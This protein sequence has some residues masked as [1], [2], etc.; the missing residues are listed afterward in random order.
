[1]AYLRIANLKKS[2]RVSRT[3]TQQVLRGINVEFKRG[4]FVAVLGESGCG[5][6]TFMNIL[7][8]LDQDYTGS[9]VLDG[10]F[11]KDYSEKKLDDYRK[12]RVGLIFQNYNLI[13]HMSVHENIEVAMTMSNIDRAERKARTQEILAQVGLSEYADKLPNQLSGGQRQR[14]AIAR[15]LANTP[16]ILLADEPPGALDKDSA[17][18]VIQILKKI[19]ESGKLVIV[20]THSQKVASAC[21]RILTIDDGVIKSDDKQYA[22]TTKTTKAQ[23]AKIQNIGLKELFKLAYSNILQTKKRSLLVSVGMSIGIAAVI[24][25]F[26]LSN[27]ITGYVDKQLAS[28]MNAL[29]MQV[30]SEASISSS[31]IE[32]IEELEGVDYVAE[33]TYVR[34][35]SFYDYG[36]DEGTI[37]LLSSAYDALDRDLTAGEI[38]EDGEILISEAFAKNLYNNSTDEAQ[39]LVGTQ[40]DITFGGHTTAFI[41]SG[42]YEDNSDYA[43]YA[44]AYVTKNNLSSMYEKADKTLRTNILYVYV[45]D[46]SYIT[47]VKESIEAMSYTVSRDDSTV[48]TLLGYVDLGTKVLTGFALISIAVSAIMIFIVT[49]TSVVE[50]TKEIG[51]LRAVGG[52]KKDVTL[53][54]ILESAM[55]GA[56]AGLIAVVFSLFISIVANLIMNQYVGSWLVSLNAVTYL[57]CF[58]ASVAV[59]IGSG[60][61]PSMQAANLDPAE[62]LRSE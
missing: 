31:R 9:I 36:G 46:T 53:L 10:E 57:C 25:V 13:S 41:I 18:Q 4:E 37:M 54:F 44:C 32:D 5:K 29:Q 16:E 22:V 49:Y 28:S 59:G 51:V 1:M 43:D 45:V 35:S 34:M 61:L 19:A 8:G 20:V 52:R 27:G 24:L 55:I 23:T 50:R 58:A 30:V 62:S 3:E 38:C 12:S 21:S 6:S 42:V 26:C 47:S 14:V 40:I 7:G 2:Y 11:L 15:A 60:L 48:E 56:F 39:E 33:G 17:E